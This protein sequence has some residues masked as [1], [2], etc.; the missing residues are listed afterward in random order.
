M[1]AK[2]RDALEA[3]TPS[4]RPKRGTSA[5]LAQTAHALELSQARTIKVAVSVL[6]RITSKLTKGSKLVLRDKDGHEEEIWLPALGL[7]EDEGAS[8]SD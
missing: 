8:A 7:G 2:H 4:P 6:S 5:T 3:R 1:R